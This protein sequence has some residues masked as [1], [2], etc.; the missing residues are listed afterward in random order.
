MRT[1]GRTL[2]LLGALLLLAT[3]AFHAAGCNMVAGWLEELPHQQSQGLQFVWLT[4]SL[5]WVVTALAWLVAGYRGAH[6]C[7]GVAILMSSIPLLTGAGILWIDPA[8]FGGCLLLASSALGVSGAAVIRN[9]RRGA[10]A[11][12]SSLAN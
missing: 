11:D 6:S 4:D 9:V 3:A 7:A 2:L 12:P 5:S 10:K 8:F 1:T